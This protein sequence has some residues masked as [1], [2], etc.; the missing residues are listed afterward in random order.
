M[1]PHVGW[2]LESIRYFSNFLEDGEG[3]YISWCEFPGRSVS[4]VVWGKVFG[5]K[6]Y[7]FSDLVG[8]ISL[9]W[10]GSG[11][12]SLLSNRPRVQEGFRKGQLC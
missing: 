3:S 12:V 5:V 8:F 4:L 11:V 7:F 9:S 6:K 1:Y 2:K 10:G